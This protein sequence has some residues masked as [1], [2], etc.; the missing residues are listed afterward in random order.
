VQRVGHRSLLR[1]DRR[2]SWQRAGLQ[3]R[4]RGSRKV[5]VR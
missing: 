1:M 5:A 2:P 3:I 4:R